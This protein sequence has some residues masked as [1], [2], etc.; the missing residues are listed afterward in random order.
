[1]KNT[2]QLSSSDI[3]QM[4]DVGLSTVSNWRSRHDDF[5][6]PISGSGASPRFD[7][8]EVRVWLKT[9][10]KKI[11]DLSAES[12][13]WNLMDRWRGQAPLEDVAQFVS[14]LLVWRTVS[15]PAS[16]GF[17]KSLS[18]AAQWPTL[19]QEVKS[20]QALYAL[21][22]S[23]HEYEEKSE[24]KYRPVFEDL[25]SLAD[26]LAQP[27]N[28][29]ALEE[30]IHTINSFNPEDL[31]SIYLAFQDLRTQSLG[32]GYLEHSTSSTLIDVMV[33]VSEDIPGPVHAPAAGVGR[34][35]FAVGTHGS[36]R[37]RLTG[38]EIDRD[39]YTKAL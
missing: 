38:Q 9:H 10:G 23:V 19:V 3:A 1:M 14:A 26:Q 37:K 33:A 25:H 5:P 28:W 31:G 2:I 17:M 8:A 36:E 18:E 22:Q 39:T 4:A 20:G 35:L 30:F 27:Q 15:D 34:L 6:E 24:D 21:Q 32:R 13:L 7:A 11:R 12:V 16:P 29:R